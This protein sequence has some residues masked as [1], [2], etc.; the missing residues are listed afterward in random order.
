MTPGQG[1][2]IVLEGTDGSGTTTQAALLVQWFEKRGIAAL[3]TR[4]PSTGPVGQLLRCAMEKRLTRAS[5]QDAT[6][7]WRT[8]ALLFAADRLDHLRQEIVPALEAGTWVISDRYALSSLIY[9]SLTAPEPDSALQ[10]VR[11][12]NAQALRPDLVL[13]LDVDADTAEERR[14]LRGGPEE[15]FEHRAL[16]AQLAQA[17]CLA[18]QYTPADD[19]LHVDGSSSLADVAKEITSVIQ[20]RLMSA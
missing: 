17:Y 18:E 15:L 7:D 4:E 1:R 11:E 14:R 3:A 13:V 8:L 20:A 6:F 10:W 19:L 12:L 5:G 2:F 16:Q 9:Q